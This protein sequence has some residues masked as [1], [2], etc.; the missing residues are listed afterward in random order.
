MKNF[1]QKLYNEGKTID[2]DKTN[3]SNIER[4]I[5]KLNDAENTELERDISLEDLQQVVHNS[6]NNK[7]PAPDDFLNEFYKVFWPQIKTLLLKLMTSYKE[8][9]ILNV[10]QTNGIITCIPK[11]GKCRSDLKNWRPITLLNSIYKFYLGILA[12]RIK[13]ILPKL[14]HVDQKGFING[15]FIGENTR[16]T[17]DIMNECK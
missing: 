13:N 8:R 1:Y 3:Y 11:G 14:I 6:K 4:N 16:I 9:G 15:T 2:I 7:S 12:E 17:L 10:A 5:P